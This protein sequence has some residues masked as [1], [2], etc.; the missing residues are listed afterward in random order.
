MQDGHTEH[1]RLRL[2]FNHKVVSLT[3]SADATV[4]DIAFA[5]GEL[6]PRQYGSPVAIDVV[7]P[8][9]PERF[10]LPREQIASRNRIFH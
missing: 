4:G 2:V 9:L 5:L 8:S 1:G 7:L 3:L 6:A 10:A